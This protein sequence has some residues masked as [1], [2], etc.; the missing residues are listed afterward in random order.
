[1]HNTKVSFLCFPLDVSECLDFGLQEK[2]RICDKMKG[3]DYIAF[4]QITNKHNHLKNFT[5][6]FFILKMTK[7]NSTYIYCMLICLTSLL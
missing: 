1:M 6:F 5:F 7:N 4:A 2:L 3:P